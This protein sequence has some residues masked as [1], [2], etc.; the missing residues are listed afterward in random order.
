MVGDFDPALMRLCWTFWAH[1]HSL[2]SKQ[3]EMASASFVVGTSTFKDGIWAPL[4]TTWKQPEECLT[5]LLKMGNKSP[6]QFEE[7][8]NW[9][10][11]AP[12]AVRKCYP[13]QAQSDAPAP[14]NPTYS[15]GACPDRYRPVWGALNTKPART[16]TVLGA[17]TTKMVEVDTI[18]KCCPL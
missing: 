15:P 18:V 12:P 1:F 9:T 11:V 14:F 6:Q 3:T 8:G 7:W 5:A 4:P 13:S 10:G 2:L 16:T 17:A